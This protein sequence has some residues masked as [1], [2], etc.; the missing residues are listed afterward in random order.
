[1]VSQPSPM[2]PPHSLPSPPPLPRRLPDFPHP[3]PASSLS[4]SPLDRRGQQLLDVLL[5]GHEP[6]VILTELAQGPLAV[7]LAVTLPGAPSVSRFDNRGTSPCTQTAAD[8]HAS[9]TSTSTTRQTCI[10]IASPSICGATSLKRHDMPPTM[11]SA[12]GSQCYSIGLRKAIA[13]PAEVPTA[14][15]PDAAF[16]ERKMPSLHMHI[17]FPNAP[18]T[19]LVVQRTNSPCPKHSTWR[20]P[21]ATASKRARCEAGGARMMES[22][23]EKSP[24]TSPWTWTDPIDQ[25]T[26]TTSWASERPSTHSPM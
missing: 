13:T 22:S 1:M 26:P 25:I 20:S 23:S 16:A 11:S 18:E 10:F 7:W 8:R 15:S 19:G 9:R 24:T 2:P 5:V 14:Y 17:N 12:L 6:G 21:S 3:V 4:L